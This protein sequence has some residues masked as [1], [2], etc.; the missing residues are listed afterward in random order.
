VYQAASREAMEEA[1]VKGIINVRHQCLPFLHS[2]PSSLCYLIRRQLD[3][4]TMKLT[5]RLI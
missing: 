4:Q 1:G 5:Y 3:L 2:L